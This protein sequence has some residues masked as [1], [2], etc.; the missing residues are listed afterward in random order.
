MNEKMKH[1]PTPWG[2]CHDG[3]CQCKMIWS[4]P[5]D[6]PVVDVI[7][8]KWGDRFASIKLVGTSLDLKAEAFMDM[9]EYGSVNDE[10]AVANAQFIV[11]AVNNYD[12]FR[13]MLNASLKVLRSCQEGCVVPKYTKDIADKIELLL[14]DKDGE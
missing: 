4:V 14:K 9:I 6:H 11:K 10:T 12:S 2:A 8:G 3:E 7:A 13:E 5:S 1:S